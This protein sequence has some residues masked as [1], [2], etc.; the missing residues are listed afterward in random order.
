MSNVQQ[1]S[2]RNLEKHNADKALPA[3]LKKLYQSRF[4]KIWSNM[5]SRCDNPRIFV[6]KNYGGRGIKYSSEWKTFEGFHRDMY[7][8]YM[9]GRTL[10]RKDNNG[11]YTPE[12]CR[13]A[14]PKEQANNT[15]KNVQYT[16]NG[17]TKNICQWI[18]E[19]GL[20]HTTVHQRIH[21]YGW[22]IEKALFTPARERRMS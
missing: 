19:S 17:I 4:Y 3:H 5:K 18:E 15:R 2:L 13:W 12:N 10:E 20:K 8:T 6:Y 11:D 16:I 1:N 9:D 22:P 21:A 7:S 14:T